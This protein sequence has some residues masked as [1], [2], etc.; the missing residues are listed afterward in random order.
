MTRS[1]FHL[2]F[3]LCALGAAGLAQP[4]AAQEPTAFT[5]AWSIYVGWIP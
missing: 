5:V 2:T 3:A 4:A 1:R